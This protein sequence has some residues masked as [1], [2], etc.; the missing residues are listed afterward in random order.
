M[1]VRAHARAE[2]CFVAEGG[3]QVC[4]YVVFPRS[5]VLGV[6][7]GKGGIQVCVYVIVLGHVCSAIGHVCVGVFVGEG[8]MWVCVSAAVLHH[9]CVVVFVG[10]GGIQVCIC[11]CPRPCVY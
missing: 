2:V 8:G 6:F 3:M 5:C 10:K 1:G 7:V 9:V 11:T 4:V